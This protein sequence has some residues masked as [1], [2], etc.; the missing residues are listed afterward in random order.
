MK[1]PGSG[2]LL[3]LFAAAGVAQAAEQASLQVQKVECRGNRS[4]SCD[5]IRN[6]MRLM[7]GA[8][9]NEA[10]IRNAQLRL[11]SLRNFQSVDVRL[12]RGAERN[13][14]IVVVEVAEASP[15]V[16][17]SL[18]GLSSRLDSTRSVVAGRIAHQNFFGAGK[19]V[20]L[21]AVAITGFAG[22]GRDEDYQVH[23]R[24]V[25][26][27][28]LGSQRYFGI[29]RASWLKSNRRDG[30]GNFSDFAGAEFDLRIG[31]RFGETSYV[32]V[33]ITFRPH[34]DWITGEWDDSGGDFDVTNRDRHS[35]LN[36]IYG[37][38]SEDD[39]YFPTRGYSFHL[40]G[41]WDFGSGSPANRSH[42]GFR[43]TWQMYDGFLIVK[44]GGAPT[45]E[46]RTSFDESQLFSVS[47]GRALQT[48]DSIK[49]GRWYIEPGVST[50]GFTP[51]GRQIY[52]VGI[53]A[54]V[55]LDTV[56][57][58]IVDLY[59]MGTQDPQR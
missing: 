4:T 35:G 16:T 6:Q 59:V 15:I 51:T 58:G 19:T 31:R 12:E 48:G 32:T 40:G 41:G 55:R 8:P 22:D 37:R 24:Y 13:S 44:L 2:L 17:E 39:L 36:I 23:L 43:K 52:E 9:L 54:G 1:V 3:F 11:S 53:K 18:V 46:Y 42:V 29:A 26:P 27:D 56:A 49:R 28:L 14:V 25:D 45:P 30:Y 21:S 10:E 5:F 20:D 34:P 7:E 47:Y 38:N 57:F 50:A 33:G